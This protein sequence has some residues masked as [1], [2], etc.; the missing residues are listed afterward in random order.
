MVYLV[1]LCLQKTIKFDQLFVNSFRKSLQGKSVE[2]S[3]RYF[4]ENLQRGGGSP[5]SPVFLF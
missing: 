3:N 5:A 4:T 2:R 1:V